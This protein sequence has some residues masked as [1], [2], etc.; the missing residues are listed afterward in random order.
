MV[1]VL[2]KLLTTLV[3]Q[4]VLAGLRVVVTGAGSKAQRMLAQ[5]ARP[6]ARAAHEGRALVGR[7]AHDRDHGV[8]LR[9]IGADGRAQ[10]GRDA[11]E[12]ELETDVGGGIFGGIGHGRS[13]PL[14]A[15]GRLDTQNHAGGNGGP[16]GTLP[17]QMRDRGQSREPAPVCLAG[18]GHSSARGEGIRAQPGW[19]D[20]VDQV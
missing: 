10:E 8:E 5:R 19:G 2:A 7:H 11:D 13:T 6:E 3:G 1:V 12:R 15:M 17:V 4:I 9:Q 20:E 14:A 16:G 18:R